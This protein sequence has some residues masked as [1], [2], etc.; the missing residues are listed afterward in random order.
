MQLTAIDWL[1]KLRC[2]EGHYTAEYI[3]AA[4]VL[5]AG[6]E[7]EYW[8][9]V[10]RLLGFL[11]IPQAR[12]YKYLKKLSKNHTEA[13]INFR[14]FDF[15]IGYARELSIIS[16]YETQRCKNFF[17]VLQ[18]VTDCSSAYCIGVSITFI[19]ICE[20]DEYYRNKKFGLKSLRLDKKQYFE[21]VCQTL[22]INKRR[23][24]TMV[25]LFMPR[26]YQLDE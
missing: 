25:N 17:D 1:K 23:L 20:N 14:D 3:V 13:R 10:I 8:I 2:K 16:Y 4:C 21:K 19:K 7:N 24:V 18:R 12:F 26:L 11:K 22:F 15:F 5:I 6:R 9:P